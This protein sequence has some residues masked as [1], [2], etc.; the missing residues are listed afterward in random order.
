[1]PGGA[2][3]TVVSVGDVVVVVVVVVLPVSSPLLQPTNAPLLMAATARMAGDQ[4]F[5]YVMSTP[6]GT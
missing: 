1:V 2:V 3:T 4:A 5:R 6:L